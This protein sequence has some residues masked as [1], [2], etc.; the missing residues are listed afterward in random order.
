M[1]KLAKIAVT[2]KK[3]IYL[4]SKNA[5]PEQL[6]SKILAEINFPQMICDVVARI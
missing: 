6:A 1:L 3:D 2:R 5:T 4:T